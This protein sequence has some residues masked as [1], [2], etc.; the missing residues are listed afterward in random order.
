MAKPMGNKMASLLRLVEERAL[1]K[2]EKKKQ[3]EALVP[4]LHKDFISNILIRLPLDALQRSRFVCKP[5]YTII[6]SPIF[7]DAHLR[8]SESV[9][10]FL[11]SIRQDNLY[12]FSLPSIPSE[13][14]NTVSVEAKFLQSESVPILSQ[15]NTNPTLKF[16][17]QFLEINDGKSKIGEY[18]LSCMGNLRATCNGLI[19]L[20]NKLKKG[21]LIVVNPVTRKWISLPPGTLCPPRKEAYGFAFISATGEY[22][23]VHLF[24][25]DLGFISCEILILD[26][27]I[28]RGV[29][30][31]SFGLLRW[32]GYMPV[33]AIGALHWVPDI[34]DSDYLVSMEVGNEKFHTINLPKSCR[35]HDRI[36]EM[37]GF[38]SLVSHD[39]EMNQIGIWILKCLGEPW[40]KNHSIK[41]GC[42]LDMVPLFS[43]RIKGDMIFKRDE[44]GSFYAYDFQLQVMTKIEMENGSFPLSG[45]HLP[46]VNSLVSWSSME[47][48]QNVFD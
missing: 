44:D 40:T 35:T 7:I 16:F 42:I 26:T 1:S 47:R 11:S 46:H 13:K 29:N 32:F 9:L 24:R 8:Q 25:D 31:P 33:S 12:P 17:I 2:E 30:G 14:P 39:E 20:D 28:W 5:W 48:S 4:Y 45:S 15:P 27:R 21:G 22:K 37:R 18:N 23:V 43:S 41:M 6:N 38:L 10:I 36:V 3:Q 19:L 34:D